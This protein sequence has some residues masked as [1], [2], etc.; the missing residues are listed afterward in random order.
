M[1]VVI[2]ASLAGL[3]VVSVPAGFN[4]QGLPMGLQLIG[5]PRADFSVLQLANAYDEATRWVKRRVPASI[6][7]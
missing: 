4:A 5:K 1:E 7:V 3:P 2:G 6:A